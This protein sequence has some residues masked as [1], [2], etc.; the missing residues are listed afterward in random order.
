MS[1]R[2]SAAS[3]SATNASTDACSAQPNSG[4]EW[5]SICD[6]GPR[7]VA[8][9]GGRALDIAGFLSDKRGQIVDSA[10]AAL[11]RVH[12]RHYEA[13]GEAETR[14]R[15]ETLFDRLLDALV[16]RNVTAMAE[17]AQ[18]V[19]EERFNAGYDLGEVQTAFNALEEATWA[20]ALA[21]LPADE[22]AEALGSVSTILGCGKDALARRYV[23]LAA[24]GHAPSLNRRALFGGTDG[25]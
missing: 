23:S 20:Q 17:Y 1:M 9:K 5:R 8:E 19:A 3:A 6:A 4:R 16:R 2:A 24:H 7:P 22:L 14:R 21:G 11:E 15:L 13:A 10:D 25:L 18:A 12:A